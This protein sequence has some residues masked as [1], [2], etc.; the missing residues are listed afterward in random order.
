MST[1]FDSLLKCLFPHGIG[2]RA[3]LAFMIVG[4]MMYSADAATTKELALLALGFYFLDRGR[5]NGNNT[6]GVVTNGN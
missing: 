5:T 1:M 3:I 6:N 2:T 4:F